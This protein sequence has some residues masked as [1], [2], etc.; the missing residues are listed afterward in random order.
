MNPTFLLRSSVSS[1]SPSTE[2]VLPSMRTSPAVGKSIAPAKFSSVDFPHP[3]R[4]TSATNS[5]SRTSR[6]TPASACTRCPSV[7]YSLKIFRSERIDMRL[8]RR[9]AGSLTTA[10]FFLISF[11]SAGNLGRGPRVYLLYSPRLV[12]DNYFLIATIS[13]SPAFF[14]SP[15][16][17]VEIPVRLPNQTARRLSHF[18]LPGTL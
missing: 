10:S 2:V 6:L 11:G 1:V 13:G 17:L 4:P 5:P 8:A 7:R 18:R 3:L 9:R 14:Q 12:P 16:K 15:P